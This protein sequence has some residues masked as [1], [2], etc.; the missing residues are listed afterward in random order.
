MYFQNFIRQLST[1]QRYKFFIE[2]YIF[3]YDHC[4]AWRTL[5]GDEWEYLLNTRTDAS[6]LHGFATVH[7]IKG[8]IFLPDGLNLK[9]YGVEFD[10]SKTN[11][12]TDE[13]WKILDNLGVVFLPCAGYRHQ[14]DVYLKSFKTEIGVY[15]S[16]QPYEDDAYELYILTDITV[17]NVLMG[18]QGMSVRLVAE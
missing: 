1:L 6:S 10:A 15:H 5:T 4:D 3:L 12:Y 16:S 17:E 7:N 13:E 2:C 9:T 11:E 18:F 14:K 8:C